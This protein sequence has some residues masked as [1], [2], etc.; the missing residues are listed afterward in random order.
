MLSRE[1]SAGLVSDG[2]IGKA[3]GGGGIAV[4]VGWG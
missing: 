3:L 4:Y 1:G 2:T